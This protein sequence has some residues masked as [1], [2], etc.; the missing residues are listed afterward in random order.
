M[1]MN[2]FNTDEIEQIKENIKY[3]RKQIKYEKDK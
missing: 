1:K 2:K 3:L